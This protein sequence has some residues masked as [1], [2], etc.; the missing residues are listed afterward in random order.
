MAETVSIFKEIMDR[1]IP[2]KYQGVVTL[3]AI[4]ILVSVTANNCFHNANKS[5]K[6]IEEELN[7]INNHLDIQDTRLDRLESKLVQIDSSTTSI[8]YDVIV[9][10][11]TQSSQFE[12]LCNIINRSVGVMG[13]EIISLHPIQQQYLTTRFSDLDKYIKTVISKD[14]QN[15][16]IYIRKK[17]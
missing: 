10:K 11:A 7:K 8:G 12:N 2:T 3:G 5:M 15:M 9:I 4:I 16:K 13:E 14:T 17:K 1:V 6:G